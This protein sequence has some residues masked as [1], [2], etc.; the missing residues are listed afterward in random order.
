[1]FNWESWNETG[2]GWYNS[3]RSQVDDIA[4]AGITHVWLPPP[5]HSVDAQGYLPGRLY[6]LNVSRYGNETQLR[7]LIAAFH[8]KGIKCVADVVL[9]HRTAES[10]DARGVYC[11]FEGGT[12]DGRLDWG[13]RMI[14]RNDSYSDGTGNADTGLDYEP[15]P[16]LDH[17]DARVRSELT[18]WLNWLRSDDVG[19]DGWRLD[20]ALGYSPAVARAYLDATAPDLA[21]AEIWTDLA[22][23]ADGEP[24]ADQ[25][26]HRQVLADWVDAVGGPAAAFDY[27][28]KGI[29]QTALNLSQ[30]FRM[31]DAQGRAPGLVGLRPAQ[32]VTFVDNHDTGSKTLHRW[33]FP[34]GMALQGY[35]YILTHPGT[36]CIFYDHFFDPNMK[37]E[38]A[39]MIKIRTRNKI[40]PASSLRILLAEND[41]Y[42]AEIDGRVLAKVGARYDVSTYVPDGFQMSTSGND[43]AIWEKSSDD[44]Q[45]NTPPPSAAISS[46]TRSRRWVVP[47]VATVAPFLVLLAC[48]AAVATLLWRR[49]EKS[50]AATNAIETFD[51]DEE[52]ELAHPADFEKGVGPRRYYYRALAAATGNFAD[53][54]KLGSGGFGPVYRGYLPGQDRHVAVKVLSPE[55]SSAQGRRQFEAE[56]RIISQLRHRNLV[57]LV[58]W[59]DSRR[60]GLLLVYELVPGGSL[61]Q[62]L[63]GGARAGRRRLLTWPER[64]TVAAGL[65][66]AL[67]Y[68]HEEWE[69]YVVH[70][71]IKPSNVMLDA[72]HG[73]KLGDFGLARL[74]DHGVGPR[75][76]RVV[77]GTMG[78]MDPELLST[79][80]PSR[81]SDVYSFG[82]VLLEVA[83]GRP[84]TAELPDGATLALPEWVWELYDRGAVL[85]AADGRLDGQF[86]AWE[87]ERVLVV[88]LWCSHPVPTERPSIVHAMNVLQS[89]DATLPQLPTNAH[90]GAAAP[91]AGFSAYVHSMSSSVGSVGDAC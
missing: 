51:D 31:Q 26:A 29:L 19:F 21:V 39:T 69:Q 72:S 50:A 44:V 13:P 52:E 38:I 54:N 46:T 90:R 57:Q 16:D 75:T 53:E 23:G 77:M 9:N 91:T 62:H 24:L 73:A 30:L 85:E 70:G 43:F 65:G 18:D 71:D 7:S 88:G 60:K 80:R 78:Y 8:G 27:T 67:V 68:L 20:F 45:T 14:C 89:R 86:D 64:Y 41:V 11:I 1:A 81:A 87:M 56:V 17:L 37:D 82:V 12:P 84:A 25:D 35:A 2:S 15:A 47:V 28:T 10:K 58:G 3:L 48:S 76:T 79:H 22:Y 40:R 61:D 32:A 49:R 55:S 42:V 36:P 33:P 4:A 59:C 66:A 83:C 5:S 34:P 6:D 63:H 74:L